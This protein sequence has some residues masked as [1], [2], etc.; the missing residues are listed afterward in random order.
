MDALVQQQKA[1]EQDLDTA[2]KKLTAARLGE[3]L[4]RNQQSE[5]LQVLEQ[6]I[7]P[8][9]PVKPNRPKLFALS[10]AVAAAAGLGT[11]ILAEM[12]DKTIRGSRELAGV[13]DSRLLVSIPYILTAGET[14]QRRRKIIFLWVA[15][16]VF[17]LV[18]LSGC[19]LHRHRDR[20]FVV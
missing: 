18:G 17:L 3:S 14:A 10:F 7:V 20:L 1:T 19:A 12:L 2:S 5:H 16:G 6:P 9:R 15:L 4:E 13:F 8:Q 11:V